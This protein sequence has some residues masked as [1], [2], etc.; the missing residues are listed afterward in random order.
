MASTSC[1]LIQSTARLGAA[2]AS[3]RP[4]VPRAQLVCKAQRQDAAEGGDAVTRR[5]ALTL[6]AGVAAVGA[7]VSPAAAAYGEAGNDCTLVIN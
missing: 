4:Q 2:A 5:A 6:L 3:A 7:K 1:F